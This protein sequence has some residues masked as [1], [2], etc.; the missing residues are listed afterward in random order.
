MSWLVEVDA[1]RCVGSGSCAA[2]APDRFVLKGGVSVPIAAELEP[3][4]A[5]VDAAEFCPVEAIAVTDLAGG[6]RV[7]PVD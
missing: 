4:D 6:R 5:V 7:A 3:D 2:V 1:A